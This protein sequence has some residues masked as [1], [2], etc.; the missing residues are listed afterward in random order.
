MPSAEQPQTSTIAHPSVWD[1]A[2][3]YRS[4]WELRRAHASPLSFLQSQAQRGDVSG[5]SIRN[6]QAVLL[7]HPSAIEDV[8]VTSGHK[9]AKSAALTRA[10]RLLGNGLLTAEP[11]LHTQ[12]KR[13]MVPAFHRQRL[14]R[15]AAIMQARAAERAATWSVGAGVDIHREMT[16]I[17]LA[18]VGDALFSTDLRPHEATIRR[19]VATAM[20]ILDPLVALVAP[21]RRLRP[22]RQQL[23]GVVESLVEPRLASGEAH[24][25]LLD[26]LIAASTPESTRTQLYDD[27]LTILLAGHDT[28]ANALTW[29][30]MFL[31][32]H[33][34]VDRRLAEE[35]ATVAGERPLTVEDLP[36]LAYTRAV[37]SEALRLRPPAWLLARRALEPHD[38][39]ERSIP[40]G[41]LV[42]MCPFLVHRD[43]RFFR[44]PLAFL[45]DRWLDDSS[46]ER[47]R[48]SFFP[49]GAG[50]RSCI[51]ESFAWMEGVVVLATLA[52][53]WRMQLVDG[54][55]DM[56]LRI[57]MRPQ[58]PVLMTPAGR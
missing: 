35:A 18:A 51:G 45:P 3:S 22:A 12:R 28:I 21:A 15:Y 55:R 1:D 17:T 9:F 56:D 54:P 50:R 30:W 44:E 52:R 39:G 5:F 53:Q 47:P 29:T 13:V 33:P 11:P 4:M 43:P 38:F 8:L 31:A 20:V 49:F 16:A 27:V 14:D 34:D 25:D 2:P 46:P 37:L 7:S 41:A 36:K 58:G 23:L 6:Q 57:T 48:L 19:S 32:Q 40:S 24:D 10:R 42:L 26:M